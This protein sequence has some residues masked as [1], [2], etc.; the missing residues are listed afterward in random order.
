MHTTHRHSS[1][2]WFCFEGSQESAG[3][4]P[5]VSYIDLGVRLY[6]ISTFYIYQ[7]VPWLNQVTVG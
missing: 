1:I 6:V 4:Y 7:G 5:W 2:W 3:F